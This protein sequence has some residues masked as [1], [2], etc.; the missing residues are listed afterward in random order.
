MKRTLIFAITS[1]AIILFSVNVFAGGYENYWLQL[2]DEQGNPVT[3]IT[4]ATIYNAGTTTNATLFTSSEGGTQTNPLT[5]FTNGIVTFYGNKTSYDVVIGKSNRKSLTISGLTK[6]KHSF[7]YA[8]SNYDIRKNIVSDKWLAPAATSSTGC[9]TSSQLETATYYG[10][11]IAVSAMLAQP[12]YA[13]NITWGCSHA[14][15]GVATSNPTGTIYIT[16]CGLDA[17]GNSV[18]ENIL[19]GTCALSTSTNSGVGNVAF[20]FVDTAYFSTEYIK[21]LGHSSSSVYPTFTI[22]WGD[23]LGMSH[24]AYGDTVF[25]VVESTSDVRPLTAGVVNGTYNTYDP[26]NACNATLNVE[27][28]YWTDDR[29][30]VLE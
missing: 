5:S 7:V 17:W 3:D 2:M 30:I 20:S 13:R 25:K 26:Y 11:T 28:W 15:L 29:D 27:I 19:A 24:K 4:S 23:K 21:Q 12:A 1:L 22:G 18:S 8:L 6:Y 16:I 9:T 10:E 14:L